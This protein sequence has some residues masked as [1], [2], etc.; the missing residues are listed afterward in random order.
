MIQ[1]Q[2][3]S[4][5]GVRVFIPDVFEDHRGVFQETYSQ[6]K[7]EALGLT[8]EFVQDSCS[9]S[10]YGTL[11]GLHGDPKMSKLITCVRG[12]I[13]DVVA[14]V[15]EDSPTYLKWE[16]FVLSERN[17]KQVYVPRGCV[18]GFIALSDDSIITYKQ[19]AL[20]DPAREFGVRYDDPTLS[21]EW[22]I[23]AV[24]VSRKDAEAPYLA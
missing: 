11:R 15:R 7:Y 19:S 24:L 14:D 2:E 8:D 16:A 10:A 20:Y 9:V 5:E 3:T 23:D 18:H 4:L 1:V 21:I 22:P 17:Y 6:G 12:R 13:Y